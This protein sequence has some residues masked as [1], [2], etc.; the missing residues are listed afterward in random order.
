MPAF[1]RVAACPAENGS[2]ASALVS[3]RDQ[4]LERVRLQRKHRCR[5][6]AAHSIDFSIR[7]GAGLDFIRGSITSLDAMVA[8]CRS[9][10]NSRTRIAFDQA[11]YA[12]GS[13]IDVEGIP[14]AAEHAYRLEA[15]GRPTFGRQ[16]LPGEVTEICHRPV[17]V[18]TIG[19][20]ETGVEVA[21]EINRLAELRADNDQSVAVR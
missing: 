14:G 11:I 7:C 19:G 1:S 2:C 21:G 18:I 10:P 17:R 12:L 20:A 15:G 5:G 13:P 16:A 9:P 4:F 6:C 8:E 3:L